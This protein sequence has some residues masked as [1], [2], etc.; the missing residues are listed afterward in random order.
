MKAAVRRILM[1]SA[2][3]SPQA[4]YALGLGDIKLN[5][6][7]N[8]PFDAEIELVAATPDDLSTLRA[9]L[10]SGDT[11][12]RYGLDRPQFLSDFGFQVVR[13][14]SRDVLRVTSTKPVTEPFVT[15]LVEANWP[16]GR[17]LREYTVLLDPPIFA[18]GPATAEAP[19][20]APR[21][22]ASAS[23]ATTESYAAPAVPAP[24]A[25]R[26]RQTYTPRVATIEPG[27]TYQVQPNDTLWKIA[28]EAHPGGRR[29][30]NRAMLAIYES[31]ASAF[32]GNIN[33]LRAGSTLRIPEEG[34]VAAISA[35]A[36]AAEVSRQYRAWQEGSGA[37][38]GDSGHLRLVTPEQ[39]SA[40][41]ST[42]PPSTTTA[43]GDLQARVQQLESEL[44]EAKRLL[45]VKNAELATL[46][47]QTGGTPATTA[48]AEPTTPPEAPAPAGTETAPA[49]E[50]P[51]AAVEPEP[52]PQAAKPKPKPAVQPAPEPESGGLLSLLGQYWW[53][54]LGLIVALGGIFYLVRKRREE[55]GG[56]SL[57]E[58]FARRD[59]D[60]RSA[61]IVVGRPREREAD[62]LVEEKRPVDVGVTRTSNL[63]AAAPA[64]AVAAS[65]PSPA[66]KAPEPTR[67]P[68]SIDDT[69]SGEL[70]PNLEAGDPL[71]EADFH[72][73]YGLYDQAA[74]L[75]QLAIKR[76]PERRD[77]RLKLL[78]IYF[79]WG[80]RDRFVEVAREMNATRASAEPGEWDKVVIMG[81]QI[82][83]DDALFSSAVAGAGDLDLDLQDTGGD[84]DIDFPGSPASSGLPDIDLTGSHPEVTDGLGLDFVLDEPQRGHGERA[85]SS[86]TTIESLAPTVESLSPHAASLAPTIESTA[87]KARS[88][89]DSTQEVDL[90]S[91]G[92]DVELP[93]ELEDSDKSDDLSPTINRLGQEDTIEQSIKTR[94]P[95]QEDTIEQSIKTRRPAQDDTLE[96]SIKTRRPPM[97]DETIEQSSRTARP[98]QED[99][100]EQAIKRSG[101]KP[102]AAA[103]EDDIASMT[104]IMRGGTGQMPAFELPDDMP[105]VLDSSESTGELPVIET[106]RIQPGPDLGAVDF[107]L[108]EEAATMSEV[109]TKLDLA[110]AYI[111]M[112]DPEGARSILEEVLQEG[113]ATQKQEAERLVSSLP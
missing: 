113:N 5:S 103:D 72:M 8:Q 73:A 93:G 28:S 106:T 16:R 12:A 27:S 35:S 108:G 78:E 50:E 42:T 83:P 4:L 52:Q 97:Q 81:K 107:S 36:A 63:G 47:A 26:P 89:S 51:P 33:V 24:A 91:L 67:K 59:T 46:Q 61:P 94:R 71:A 112:G 110:R 75:V 55:G 15:L 98:A 40:A 45:E 111:D 102:A 17:L 90:E 60:L 68:V 69:M 38:A 21:S 86:Q 43:G 109:G 74:D 104:N 101:Q 48:P 82:A 88:S 105:I 20:E 62:I 85:S 54:L 37:A 31:N 96:Q 6:A 57:E 92:L 79:V 10:A 29:D 23:P 9:T 49:A 22:A 84:M 7:L 1:L 70:A 25:S 76:E 14:G 87:L 18:P 2:M 56:E 53:A 80:N 3:L 32:E 100:I 64:A 58:A 44:A 39:G 11:F 77:L 66:P 95:P 34:E 13:S 41:A 65:A 30:V 99:T 19:V